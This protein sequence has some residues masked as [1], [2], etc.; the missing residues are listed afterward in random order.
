MSDDRKKSLL[1]TI[2]GSFIKDAKP[3][4]SA[5]LA[6]KIKDKVSPAT[7]RNDLVALEKDGFIFQPHTSAGR[8][9]TQKA[10]EFYVEN[11]L[12]RN[13]GLSSKEK[14]ILQE[15]E[16]ENIEDRIKIKNFARVISDLSKQGVM[17]TF[18]ECDNYYT[19]LSNIF[20][21][22]EFHDPELVVNLTKV[23]EHLDS[24]II[25][26]HKK[27]FDEAEIM[28][29]DKNPMSENCSLI[30][31]KYQFGKYKGIIALLGPMRMDYQKNYALIKESIKLLK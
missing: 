3:I 10:Y 8:I 19:G 6:S 13:K 15:L 2:I 21:Q 31:S 18:S 20:A 17:A 27:D 16:K 29:G 25:D 30:V 14:K 28:I 12:D 22:S 4:A 11:F 5:F 24:K 9:P 26:L 1:K 23:V 7:V